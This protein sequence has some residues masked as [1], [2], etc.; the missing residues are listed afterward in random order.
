MFPAIS[1]LFNHSAWLCMRLMVSLSVW[2]C[3]WP[4]AWWFIR[5][6]TPLEIITYYTLLLMVFCGA[7]L[8]TKWR[9]GTFGGLAI[10]VSS[11]L[12]EAH[13]KRATPCLTVFSARA[14]SGVYYRDRRE[15]LFADPG[16]AD[17]I[18][19][20]AIP[21]LHA[22]GVSHVPTLLLTHGDTRH[23]SG[24]PEFIQELQPDRVVVSPVRSRSTV[25]RRLLAGLD[26]SL[27]AT[28]L[29]AGDA[30]GGWQIL[31]PGRQDTY[32]RAD[33]A[34]VVL[35]KTINGCGVLLLSDLGPVGQSD[36]LA[37]LPELRAEIVVTG[38]PTRGEAITDEFLQWVQPKLVV[39]SDME[40]PVTERASEGLIDRLRKRGIRVV[41]TR[42]YGAVKI[43]FRPGGWRVISPGGAILADRA[44]AMRSH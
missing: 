24:T 38:L 39:I 16:S 3:Q 17:S 30:V 34:S 15:E 8:K 21:F 6:P 29:A 41:C 32:S 9:L 36:L 25:Y 23:I 43:E 19:L 18:K 37:R 11:C 7:T 10:L 35:W 26:L 42:E 14:G 40:T 5:S 44:R 22:Q 27:S 13:L 4:A 20:L 33:D 12:F 1:E 2:F 31:H 28:R